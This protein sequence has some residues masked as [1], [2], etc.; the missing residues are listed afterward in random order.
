M[1]SLYGN[2]SAI[3][4]D[5]LSI[6]L[7]NFLKLPFHVYLKDEYGTIIECNGQFALCGFHGFD[8]RA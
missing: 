4:S 2:S 1:Q 6:Q 7:E 8:G 5:S 3:K